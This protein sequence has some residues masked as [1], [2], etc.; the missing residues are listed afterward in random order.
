MKE[1]RYHATKAENGYW[2]LIDL[3][4]TATNVDLGTRNRRVAYRIVRELNWAEENGYNTY[5]KGRSQRI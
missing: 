2:W 5:P 3:D 4:N 1:K